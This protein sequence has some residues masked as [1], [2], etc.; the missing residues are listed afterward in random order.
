MGRPRV[1]DYFGVLGHESSM[2]RP[3]VMHKLEV[4]RQSMVGGLVHFWL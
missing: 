4:A 3:C 2:V 1:V